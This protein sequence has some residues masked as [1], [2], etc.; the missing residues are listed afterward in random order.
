MKLSSN[1]QWVQEISDQTT[2]EVHEMNKEFDDAIENFDFLM[3][4]LYANEVERIEAER[5]YLEF[6]AS[7]AGKPKGYF[8][9]PTLHTRKLSKENIQRLKNKRIQN[10]KVLSQS[11]NPRAAAESNESYKINQIISL[12]KK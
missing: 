8:Q 9:V 5:K 3:N 2:R 11:Q 6:L 10:G 4:K 12:L 7:N 1:A